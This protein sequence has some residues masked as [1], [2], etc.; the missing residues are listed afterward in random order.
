[1]KNQTIKPQKPAKWYLTAIIILSILP[2]THY[3]DIIVSVY[4]CALF[5]GMI[6]VTVFDLPPEN[7]ASCKWG[8]VIRIN[9]VNRYRIS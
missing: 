5:E 8:K 3:K 7:S 4:L 9:S 1:M 2:F 6:L